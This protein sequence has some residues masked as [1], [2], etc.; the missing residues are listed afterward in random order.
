MANNAF[1]RTAA[2]LK[3]ERIIVL[4]AD[5]MTADELAEH[6]YVH[7]RTAKRYLKHLLNEKPR[8]IR[9]CDWIELEGVGRKIPVLQ[10]GAGSNAR[11]PK[12]LTD[13]EVHARTLADPS[14]HANRCAKN[15]ALWHRNK[16]QKQP[17][18]SPFAALGI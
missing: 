5:P 3:I 15:R 14:R 12:P 1:T 18:A 17:A 7:A 9:V 16:G 10:S 8:R 2:L 13:A 4:L 6:L 11:K